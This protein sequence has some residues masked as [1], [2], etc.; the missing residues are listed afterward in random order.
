[1][2][3]RVMGLRRRSVERG[4]IHEVVGKGGGMRRK[5]FTLLELVMVVIIIGILSS[6]AL[7]QFLKTRERARMTEALSILGQIR[8]SQIRYYIEKGTYANAIGQLDFD[9]S[10]TGALVGTSAYSYGI[11]SGSNVEFCANATR[12]N[13]SVSLP[14]AAGCAATG[15]YV[16][17]L[18]ANGVFFGTDCQSTA[19]TCS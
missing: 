19:S 11:T 18:N 6:I 9:P 2:H 17:R 12:N 5:G 7:P 14:A 16:I 4:I 13:S 10:P 1:M 15:N 8:S 3:S